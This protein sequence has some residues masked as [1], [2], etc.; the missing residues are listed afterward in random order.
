MDK[1]TKV[2]VLPPPLYPALCRPPPGPS[3]LQV[4]ADP[5]R[6]LNCDETPQPLDLPQKGKRAQVAKV[7]G[8]PAR[9]A[10]T[11]N[12]ENVT[13]QMTWSLSGHNY[14]PQIVV[15]RKTLDDNMLIEAPVGA[16]G[17]NDTVDVANQQ[18][19]SCLI[20]R[21][22]RGMQT[23]A[24]FLQFLAALD[25]QITQ[26]SAA[27]VAAG[28]TPILRPVVLMLD[29]H[30]SRYDE[31]VLAAATGAARVN[32]RVAAT[33]SKR[34]A[35]W[36]NGSAARPAAPSV[37]CARSGRVWRHARPQAR[38]LTSLSELCVFFF[39]LWP[40]WVAKL[41]LIRIRSGSLLYP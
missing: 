35:Q 23:G 40:L 36:L 1:D 18:T 27:E 31:E 17:F 12:Q 14:G 39:R 10:A 2:C 28:R 24:S 19:R 33:A 9:E 16:A 5:R 4:I 8:K 32:P 30:A 25:A 7:K 29:N 6:L 34:P 41:W 3:P 38:L 20:S 15:K 26:L 11:K 13:V 22:D 21:T 37:A